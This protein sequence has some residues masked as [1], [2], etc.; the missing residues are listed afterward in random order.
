MTV[1]KT[2]VTRKPTSAELYAV[3]IKLKKGER[4]LIV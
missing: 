3:I 1:Q 2:E 4:K